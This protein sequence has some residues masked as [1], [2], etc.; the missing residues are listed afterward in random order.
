VEKERGNFLLAKERRGSFSSGGS[1][2]GGCYGKELKERGRKGKMEAGIGQ[3]IL[4]VKRC[5]RQ[6]HERG[7]QI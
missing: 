3:E 6:M 5:K 1:D 2:G 7:R 4:R